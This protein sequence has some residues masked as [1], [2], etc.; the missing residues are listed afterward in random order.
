MFLGHWRGVVEGGKIKIVKNVEAL[1]RQPIDYFEGV[2]KCWAGD[3]FR[4]L[5]V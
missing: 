4:E 3:A 2:G 1:N 5:A